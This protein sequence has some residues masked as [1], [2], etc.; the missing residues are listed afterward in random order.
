MR[1]CA[2]NTLVYVGRVTEEFDLEASGLLD[3]LEGEARAERAELIPWLL[4]RGI[5]VEEIRSAYQPMLLVSRRFLGEDGTLLSAREISEQ[6]GLDLDFL[7]RIQRA[8][9]LAQ[10]DD[11]D[12]KV[13]LRTDADAAGYA[14]KFL[15]VGIA[16]DQLVLVVQVLT[17]GLTRAT[18]VMRYTALSAIMQSGSTELDIAKG[19]EVLVSAVAPLLGPMVTELLTVQLLRQMDTEAINASE[20]AEG[21]ALPGAREVTIAFADLVGFTKLGEVVAPEDLERLAHQL[22]DLAHQVTTPP[23]RYV[24]SIGDE[25]MLVSSDPVA[26][27][28][29]V[30][31][32]VAATEAI[33]GFP[34][35]RTGI[36]TGLAVGRA[37]DWYGSPVNLASR[38]TS[39]AR[40]GAVLVAESTRDAMPDDD[41]FTWS[42]AHS[43]KLKGIKDEVKLYRVRRT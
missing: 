21:R 29:A 34:R 7:E 37:G 24:K 11:P 4:E 42:F 8:S 20:R 17:E 14:R 19:S 33:E 18:E 3:G 1:N 39:A 30:L 40:P 13:Y 26:M 2:E 25:V 28:D 6:S 10:V 12:A 9:G 43:R 27:V 32:L 16:P 36:A 15:D 5:T 23:V 22:T 31:D 35:L 41:R 38:I